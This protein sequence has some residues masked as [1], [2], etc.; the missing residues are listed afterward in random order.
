MGLHSPQRWAIPA[1]NPAL[2]KDSIASLVLNELTVPNPLVTSFFQNG[3]AK[4]AQDPY[5]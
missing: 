4:H 2:I 5:L 3:T 1:S